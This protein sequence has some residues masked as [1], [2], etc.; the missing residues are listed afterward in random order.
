MYSAVPVPPQKKI[1]KR[2]RKERIIE[3]KEGKGERGRKREGGKGEGGKGEG[4]KGEGGRRRGQR[5]NAAMA[6]AGVRPREHGQ[7]R[8]DTE[9]P[10]TETAK[11][12]QRLSGAQ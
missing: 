7:G 12:P 8:A 1:S 11:G 2:K 6:T 10:C 9:D 4:G 3:R 5:G